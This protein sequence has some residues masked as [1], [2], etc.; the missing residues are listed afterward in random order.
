[1]D[2]RW[3]LLSLAAAAIA[4]VRLRRTPPPGGVSREPPPTDPASGPQPGPVS[5]PESRPESGPESVRGTDAGPALGED[6][7]TSRNPQ[8]DRGAG[9]QPPPFGAL[10][11]DQGLDRS[12]D[13]ALD[14]AFGAAIGPPTRPGGVDAGHQPESEDRDEPDRHPGD[15]AD[16]DARGAGDGGDPVGPEAL[17]AALERVWAEHV[18]DADTLLAARLRLLVHR[19]VPARALRPAPGARTVRVV[20]A[21]GTVVLCRGTGQGDFGRL[22]LAMLHHSVRLGSFRSANDG[23]R[24]EFRWHPDHR[25]AAVA[26]G[27]DQPD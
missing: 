18:G 13:Q 24:L 7:G 17:D 11:G 14:T 4:A 1:M 27:L 23:T 3:L 22:G 5:G 6:V 25:L 16:A 26:V 19:G 10:T 2:W 21:D 15:D 8:R 9:A 20:F 12:L